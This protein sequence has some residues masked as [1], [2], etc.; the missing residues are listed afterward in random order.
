MKGFAVYELADEPEG[1][2]FVAHMRWW[3]AKESGVWVDFTPRL[4]GH[5]QMVLLESSQAEVKVPLPPTAERRAAAEAR[6]KLG[7]FVAPVPVALP[8]S[9]KAGGAA[10]KA[11]PPAPA[12]LNFQGNEALEDMIRL[13]SAG[14]ADAKAKAAAAVAAMAATGTDES[15]RVVAAGGVP[16]LL[17]LLREKGETQEHAARALM[18]IADCPDHA[19][20]LT[21]AGAIPAA[22][23]LLREAPLGA[24][25]A[26][27]GIVG[28]LAIQNP[29]N[30]LAIVAAGALPPLVALLTKGAAPAKE[31]ACF[32]LWNLAC[33]QPS[34]M[35]AIEAAGAIR[36]L[37]ALL[38][39]GTP[40]VQEEA[41]GALMNLAAHPDN[42]RAIAAANAID[43]LVPL[44]SQV[45]LV[46][47][48]PRRAYRQTPGPTRRSSDSSSRW[49]R[50]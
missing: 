40:G 6:A 4:P 38:T 12:K 43:A 41:A 27:A 22:V 14:N 26:A 35:R 3:N 44:L 13:L 46:S 29:T 24:Q 47:G 11:P 36:P 42:K 17:M 33:Q 32:A 19:K 1:K 39:K 9:E 7:G 20:I 50:E 21:R 28:N 49:V 48:F 23:A 5:D 25:D 34:N 31:Q 30:Q 45:R 37:V 18:A 16:P 10:K 2:A 15:R 8:T